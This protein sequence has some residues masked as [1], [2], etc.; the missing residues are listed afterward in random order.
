[1]HIAGREGLYKIM[2]RFW[3]KVLFSADGCWLWSR[4]TT[5]GGYGQFGVGSGPQRMMKAHRMAWLLTFG[6]IPNDLRVL[7]HC[8]NPPCV[9]PD[10]LFLGTLSDNSQDMVAKG[11]NRNQ[12][13]THCPAGHAYD[14]ENT[15]WE[16][17]W[18]K[19]RKCGAHR[20]RVKRA[21]KKNENHA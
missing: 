11:R 9:R 4:S 14:L 15:H 17:G 18:R 10:H 8:D 5:H 16:S 19:C 21:L 12:Q 20:A 2:E 7:H 6:E 3:S 13:K 1:M